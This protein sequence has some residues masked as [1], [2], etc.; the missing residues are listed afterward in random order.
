MAGCASCACGRP[1]PS[2]CVEPFSL[3]QPRIASLLCLT[4]A[5]SSPHPIA[6][7]ACCCAW[8][9]GDTGEAFKSHGDVPAPGRAH[10]VFH[11]AERDQQFLF[12]V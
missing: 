12:E 7:P 1:L 6:L 8:G 9:V 2:L 4:P 3:P 10:P 11:P 5:S